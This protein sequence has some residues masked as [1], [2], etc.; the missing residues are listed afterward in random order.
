MKKTINKG[1]QDTYL[2]CIRA[3]TWDVQDSGTL[4]TGARSQF[5]SEIFEI[6]S[7]QDTR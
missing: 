6:N 7:I 1:I 2:P 3:S 4:I 5:A